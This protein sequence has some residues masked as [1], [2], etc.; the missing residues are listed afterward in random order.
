MLL[1]ALIA[2]IVLAGW[3]IGV[4]KKSHVIL[5][6]SMLHDNCYCMYY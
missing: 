3:R 6:H 4:L 2:P 5:L 1:L